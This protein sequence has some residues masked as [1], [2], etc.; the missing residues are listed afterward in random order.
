[1][2]KETKWFQLYDKF[3]R[4]ENFIYI[5]KI[6]IDF[7]INT[8]LH[9]NQTLIKIGKSTSFWNSFNNRL[10]RHRSTW[11]S[12]NIHLNIDIMIKNSNHYINFEKYMEKMKDIC[13]FFYIDGDKKTV[14]Y[15]EKLL[16]SLIGIPVNPK[17]FSSL[18]DAKINPTEILFCD[19]RIID[20]IQYRFKKDWINGSNNI[21]MIFSI[22]EQYN[23]KKKF[24]VP[25]QIKGVILH[26]H[27]LRAYKYERKKSLPIQKK[28]FSDIKETNIMTPNNNNN[29]SNNNSSNGNNINN[30]E[31]GINNSI[32]IKTT[33]IVEYFIVVVVSYILYSICSY[34]DSYYVI[35]DL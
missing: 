13:A 2:Y 19:K 8:N 25:I 28:D 14:A 20:H 30:K 21:N 31:E 5:F 3:T 11:K 6:P 23:F 10:K 9:S 24:N 34:V 27:I 33:D 15:Y 32:S 17:I 18:F 35:Y 29:N 16:Q 22:I 7:K 12:H 1:M 26:I 4:S